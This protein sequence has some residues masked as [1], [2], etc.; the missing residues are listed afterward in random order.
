LEN[1]QKQI[2]KPLKGTWP[3]PRFFSAILTL[4]ELSGFGTNIQRLA[5]PVKGEY[6]GEGDLV[7][8]QPLELFPDILG[9]QLIQ[10]R[11]QPSL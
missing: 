3:D 10:L 8:D 7:C 9:Q 5:S 1:A 4:A 6:K 11:R 2:F